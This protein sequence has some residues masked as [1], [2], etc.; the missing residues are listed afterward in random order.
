MKMFK[1][2]LCVVAAGCL[3]V[4]GLS[5]EPKS[6]AAETVVIYKVNRSVSDFPRK[7]DFSMP[8]S[9]H[10]TSITLVPAS[11]DPV[12]AVLG[13]SL[14]VVHIAGDPGADGILKGTPI[15]IDGA[16]DVAWSHAVVY[17]NFF[18]AY[19]ATPVDAAD[20]SAQFRA[21]WDADNLYLLVEV[22]D[23]AL[24]LDSVNGWHDDGIE[25]YT[26]VNDLNRAY[27]A[28]DTEIFQ[29]TSVID[30][31]SPYPATIT[32]GGVNPVPGATIKMVVNTNAGSYVLEAAFPWAN[33]A[34][35][36]Y[37]P[38][39]GNLI[40]FGI[41][42][43]DDDDGDAVDTQLMW[44]T[45]STLLWR[46]SV[47]FPTIEI[48]DL[49]SA[50]GDISMELLSETNAVFSWDT[51]AW[52]RYALQGKADL[53]TGTW[54]NIIPKLSGGAGSVTVTSVVDQVQYFYR[55]AVDE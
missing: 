32:P 20:L 22:S 18:R 16:Y 38:A 9:A 13:N 3:L 6:D 1:T 12:Y 15:A 14:D 4:Q 26:D 31:T 51:S 41:A 5:A 43:N 23:E 29:T 53:P 10:D 46:N 35:G 55:A 54:S 49:P 11:T 34:A 50:I 44:V 52:G 24:L 7:E 40:G 25:I 17:A 37:T 39:G 21:M 19:G 2:G 48:V 28:G 27:G 36:G 8:E 47:Y 33:L 42:I 45:T 30:L